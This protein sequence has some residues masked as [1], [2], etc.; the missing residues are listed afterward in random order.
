[1]ATSAGTTKKPHNGKKESN[2][3]YSQKKNDRNQSVGAVLIYA[4]VLQQQQGNQRKQ[5]A[6]RRQFTKINMSFAQ[7]LQNMLKAELITLKDPPQDPNTSS[8]LYNPNIRCA[9]HS[10]CPGHDTN[11]C[12]A[13]KNKIQ[14]MIDAREIEF[15]P[16]ET[17]N[18]ITFP[19]PNHDKI[20]NA[21]DDGSYVSTVGD[22]TTPLSIVNKKLL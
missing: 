18:V 2:V 9:Y 1:M 14:D 12:W 17:P 13:L 16:P 11:S 7:A 22:L 19:M 21:V 3:V 10:N 4:P 8:P 20:V 15:D 5:D 6:P